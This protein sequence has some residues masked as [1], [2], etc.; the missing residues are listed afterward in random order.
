MIITWQTA[1]FAVGVLAVIGIAAA[2]YPARRAAYLPPI[3]ALRYEM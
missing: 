1:A 3:E 2:T